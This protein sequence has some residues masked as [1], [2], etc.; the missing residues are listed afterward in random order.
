MEHQSPSYTK[1]IEQHAPWCTQFLPIVDN[2][3]V[4]FFEKTQCP[5]GRKALSTLQRKIQAGGT[6]TA[7]FA[8]Q[9]NIGV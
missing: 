7:G 4:V 8:A 1:V 3:S 9:E 5:F 2:Q 6:H